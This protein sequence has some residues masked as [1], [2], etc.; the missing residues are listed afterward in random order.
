MTD[1]HRRR[2]AGEPVGPPASEGDRRT[3]NPAQMRG[4]ARS[5][6]GGS[7][8]SGQLPPELRCR[9]EELL[10]SGGRRLL[11]IAGAPGAGKS[12]LSAALL[13]AFP[14]R[15]VVVPMD[16]FHLA[17]SELE[18]IGRAGRKGAPDTFDAGGY[19]ALLRRLLSSTETVYA[20]EYRRDLHNAVAGAIPVPPQV[21]LVITEGNYLLLD[22]HGFAPVRGLMDECWFVKV[23]EG[24]RWDR[25]ER[26]HIATGKS[27]AAA[28][29]WTRGPDQ[30]NAEVVAATADRA[31]RVVHLG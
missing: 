2:S 3:A 22:Q 17:Q 19:V 29:E 10:A 15:C 28:R 13:S 21:P 24:L 6:S 31:D 26:R 7:T 11:G 9:V 5:Q 1:P 20:P 25:L 18:R 8:P 30:A 27:P 14:G 16:G 12:T 23:D 4:T